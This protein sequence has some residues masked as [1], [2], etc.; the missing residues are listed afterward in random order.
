MN[1]I[2]PLANHNP[3]VG[4]SN[5]SAAIFLPPGFTV[6]TLSPGF[7]RLSEV[8]LMACHLRSDYHGECL[9]HFH[10]TTPMKYLPA[11]GAVCLLFVSSVAL[12]QQISPNPN[13]V[14]NTITVN[15]S[16]AINDVSFTN[17]GTINFD[18]SANATLTN[19]SGA[20]LTNHGWLET[21][22]GYFNNSGT[23]TNKSGGVLDNIGW[24]TNESGGMLIN[25]SGG[26]LRVR[27][28][29][30]NKSGGTVLN[31]GKIR[32]FGYAINESGGTLI[33][34]G[35]YEGIGLNNHGTLINNGYWNV[36]DTGLEGT[37]NQGSWTNNGTLTF[38]NGSAVYTNGGTLNNLGT[39]IFN[40]GTLDTTGGSFANYGTLKGGGKIK[41]SYTDHG[42]IKPGN[43][44]G[45]MTID[46]DYFK[47]DGTKEIELGGLFDGGG[48]H[49][50]TEFDWI[51][52]T[53]N[54]EL[55][56][57][58]HVELIDGFEK[59]INRGQVFEE[60]S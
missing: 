49:A 30:T 4:G 42:H 23:V 5:V 6:R 15:T 59:R 27:N 16:D 35:H 1:E 50:I 39:L 54:V 19:K 60:I 17:H 11:L 7:L 51:D 29:L 33:N 13:P 32:N 36:E 56:G 12:S 18:T 20:T 2:P 8:F 37:W 53:G 22:G 46:G 28:K 21:L 25:E 40:A 45:V 47:V 48:D 24:V 44:A 58:L 52:V 9:N 10:G 41:G 26:D 3:R 34:T 31:D 43:S 14:G 57:Q 55:A 38:R